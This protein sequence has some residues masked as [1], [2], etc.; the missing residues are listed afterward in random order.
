MGNCL[1]NNNN[2]GA[3]ISKDYF[4]LIN[5]ILTQKNETNFN[6]KDNL[7]FCLEEKNFDQVS[8]TSLQY[9]TY[10]ENNELKNFINWLDFIYEYLSKEYSHERYWAMQM[11]D[12]L[13]KERFESETK[14]LSQFFIEEFEIIYE[15]KC[16]QIEKINRNTKLN[17]DNST[18]NVTQNLGGSFGGVTTSSEDFDNSAAI[19]YKEYRSK[20]KKYILKF[21]QH[22][23]N[24]D[25]P[26]NIIAQ[27]F[28]KIWVKYAKIK[29][30]LIKEN[31]NDYNDKNNI[32]IIKKKS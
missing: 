16:I 2:K 31:F 19:K 18:L 10:E 9:L 30:D 27:I 22:I 8:R 28:E 23:L 4:S 17:L 11:I 20:I 1:P 5:K 7:K 32:T 29:I 26:I 3:N 15:P 13:N 6:K 24:E 12:A 25:H 21:K 14:Y